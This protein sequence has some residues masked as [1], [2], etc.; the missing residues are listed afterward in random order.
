MKQLILILVLTLSFNASA[1]DAD[2]TITLVVRGQGKTL[3]EAKQSAVRS[4]IEQAYGVFISAK[5]DILND[6]LLADQIFSHTNG[7]LESF[8]ILSQDQLPD[9]TWI[10]IVRNVVSA[11]KLINFVRNKGL[12]A[13]IKGGLFALNIRQQLSN[14]QSEVDILYQTVGLLHELMQI[15]F[16]FRLSRGNPISM[17]IENKNWKIPI[18]VSAVGNRNMD[19][20]AEIFA[21]ALAAVSLSQSEIESYQLLNKKIYPITVVCKGLSKSYSFRREISIE[22]IRSLF[23]N[24]KFYT[25]CYS[26]STGI[27]E[28]KGAN[29]LAYGNVTKI[30]SCDWIG[31]FVFND[32]RTIEQLEKMSGYSIKP[33][34]VISAFKHGGYVVSEENGR[35]LIMSLC[36]IRPYDEDGYVGSNYISN[37]WEYAKNSC[38]N[39]ILGGYSDWRLPTIEEL[40]TIHK[41]NFTMGVGNLG[42]NFGSRTYWSSKEGSIHNRDH[43]MDRVL[44]VEFLNNGGVKISDPFKSNPFMTRPVRTF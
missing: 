36:D 40:K 41:N 34:G 32:I 30:N 23:S 8:E 28:I 38:D 3:E 18:T 21:K 33:R 1:Q 2:K 29:M 7:N 4:A 35:G 25:S 10:I 43:G 13:E 17:D 37:K 22:I 27:D 11:G 42:Y 44:T 9:G 26:I 15:S 20:C 12:S 5:T 19:L 31:E 39:L 16:D 14:E 24:M 6:Q